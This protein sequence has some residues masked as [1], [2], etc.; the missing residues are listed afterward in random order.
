MNYIKMLIL[1]MAFSGIF[2]VPA[3]GIELEDITME[4]LD[5]NSAVTVGIS[6]SEFKFNVLDILASGT[7]NAT[8]FNNLVLDNTTLMTDAIIIPALLGALLNY[9]N[10]FIAGKGT[11]IGYRL[12]KDMDIQIRVYNMYGYEVARNNY[13]AGNL[14][15]NGGYNKVL[16]RA[17]QLPVGVYIYILIY[18]NR[19]LGKSKMA[20]I[21]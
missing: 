7:L 17:D 9:P 20:I 8:T 1:L 2:L 4:G 3:M 11:T 15:G 21:K 10:P 6:L 16:F 14:G 12:S 19:V 18:D 5:V 13:Q